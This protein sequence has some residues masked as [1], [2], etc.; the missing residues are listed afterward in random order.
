MSETF[1]PPHRRQ[2]P[3]R[4]FPLVMPCPVCDEMVVRLTNAAT[5]RRVSTLVKFWCE[6]PDYVWLSGHHPVHFHPFR[7]R[8]PAKK[9][10]TPPVASFNYPFL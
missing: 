1:R 9:R 6:R 4:Y 8:P 7:K 10:A 5:G 2:S 3:A